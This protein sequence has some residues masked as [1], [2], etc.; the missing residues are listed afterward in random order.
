[1]SRVVRSLAIAFVGALAATGCKPPPVPPSK[2]AFVQAPSGDVAAIV[3]AERDRSRLANERV[4]VYVGASWCEPCR[5]FHAAVASGALDGKMPNT[6]FIEFDLDRDE[7]RLEQAGYRSR[8][9]PL[10]AAPLSDGRASG[11]QIA[12][13]VKGQDAA[14]EITPR[15]LQL[16]SE[17][18]DL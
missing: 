8:F 15:L 3:R 5:R 4:I 17:T 12:G 9:I 14:D 13:S 10:F 18:R 6:V 2:L 7:Q 11:K 16:L 1:M